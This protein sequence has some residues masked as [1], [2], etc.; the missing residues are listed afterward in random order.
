MMQRL[1]L[2]V[3]YP[4]AGKTTVSK[5]IEKQTGAVH[6]CADAERHALFPETT[7]SAEESRELYEMLNKRVDD[8]LEDGK[9]VIYDTNF[10]HRSDRDI[11]RAL[12]A[13]RKVETV[14]VWVNTP[15][16][17]ARQR[18]VQSHTVRNGYSYVMSE[19]QF[20]SIAN[21]L[22]PPDE[23]ENVIKIDGTEIDSKQITELL[24]L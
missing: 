22:E 10:N 5:L 13:N 7:H 20:E 23:S 15:L 19:D 11:L 9:S 24:H 1:F 6:I 12:A 4:G 18:A 14:I 17:I 8:L 16:E 2:F 21:K 3:G